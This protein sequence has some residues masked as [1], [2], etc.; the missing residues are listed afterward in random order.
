MFPKR[1]RDPKTVLGA[2]WLY[3]N[4]SSL[5]WG[6]LK[7]Q[8]KEHEEALKEFIAKGKMIGT[9]NSPKGKAESDKENFDEEAQKLWLRMKNELKTELMENGFDV[10]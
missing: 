1:F 8:L 5:G 10:E 9:T 2:L 6:K 4:N 7:P 3:N